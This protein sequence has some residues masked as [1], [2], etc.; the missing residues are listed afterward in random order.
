MAFSEP[1][2]IGNVLAKDCLSF[3]NSQLIIRT[4]CIEPLIEILNSNASHA[5]IPELMNLWKKDLHVVKK[6][7]VIPLLSC[8][9]PDLSEPI[10]ELI[11][12]HF[13]F[14]RDNVATYLEDLMSHQLENSN[15]TF[16]DH[17]IAKFFTRGTV[18]LDHF[19]HLVGRLISEYSAAFS[20]DEELPKSILK[21]YQTLLACCNRWLA[22]DAQLFTEMLSQDGIVFSIS[23]SI[24]GSLSVQDGKSLL[25]LLLK[26]YNLLL[27]QPEEEGRREIVLKTDALWPILL[28]HFLVYTRKS[29]SLQPLFFHLLETLV[30]LIGT[31]SKSHL[32]THLNEYVASKGFGYR[33]VLDGEFND[34]WLP[35]L[36][37]IPIQY[38]NVPLIVDNYKSLLVTSN[39]VALI[40]KW[41]ESCPDSVSPIIVS[42]LV[43]NVENEHVLDLLAILSLKMDFYDRVWEIVSC[44]KTPILFEKVIAVLEALQ[45]QIE[46]DKAKVKWFQHRVSDSLNE[47]SRM[48][49][50]VAFKAVI[51]NVE[52]SLFIDQ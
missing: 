21:A 11:E 32:L 45:K 42:Y 30:V 35:L 26:V 14:C 9:R 33:K 1:D 29:E 3:H 51:R 52:R 46:N 39:S 41:F 34:F 47:L 48:G 20:L 17:F 13:I 49:S 28:N 15:S 2:S 50:T 43:K 37:K 40:R 16:L 44:L 8:F 12:S 7:M 24:R 18:E 38:L 27:Q 36:L 6:A 4:N 31:L 10:K 22:L 5:T 19:N 25:S 23:T